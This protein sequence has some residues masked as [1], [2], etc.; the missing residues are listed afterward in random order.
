MNTQ[1]TSHNHLSSSDDARPYIH[2]SKASETFTASAAAVSGMPNATALFKA[3]EDPKPKTADSGN[4]N[5]VTVNTSGKIDARPVT[6]NEMPKPLS[7][8]VATRNQL[9]ALETRA[10]KLKFTPYVPPHL[11]ALQSNKLNGLKEDIPKSSHTQTWSKA[12]ASTAVSKLDGTKK[13]AEPNVHID[14]GNK[15]EPTLPKPDTN[16]H[17]SDTPKPDTCKSD[18]RTYF[19]AKVAPETAAN[20]QSG[21]QSKKSGS[22]AQRDDN[23]RADSRAPKPA[24]DRATQP[25]V[26]PRAVVTFGNIDE[27]KK[28]DD[29]SSK[30]ADDSKR[31]NDFLKNNDSIIEKTDPIIDRAA[32]GQDLDRK[33]TQAPRSKPGHGTSTT[34]IKPEVSKKAAEVQHSEDNGIHTS[35]QKPSYSQAL[36]YNSTD[37]VDAAESSKPVQPTQKDLEETSI[38]SPKPRVTNI[39]KV[40]SIEDQ[41]PAHLRNLPKPILVGPVVKRNAERAV[42]NS[43]IDE[44][45]RLER[46]IKRNEASHK[47]V[48]D[49]EPGTQYALELASNE[50]TRPAFLAEDLSDMDQVEDIAAPSLV[51][52]AE[53]VTQEKAWRY[54]NKLE[55]FDSA[56]PGNSPKEAL[57]HELAGWDG[58]WMTPHVE[59]DLRQQFNH[60]NK[61]QIRYL[62]SWISGRVTE[63]LNAPFKVDTT[64]LDWK[65]GALPASGTQKQYQIYPLD[66][67]M[68]RV[69]LQYGPVDWSLTPTEKPNDPYSHTE[70]RMN[71]S[72]RTSARKFHKE[73]IARLKAREL[74][75]YERRLEIQEFE[76]RKAQSRAEVA[77]KANIYLRPV[78]ASDGA[79]LAQIYNYYVKE[80]VHAPEYED[81]D[82]A[83]WQ[84]RINGARDEKLAFLVAVL[85][86]NKI[87]G[88]G[89]N[90]GRG[91]RGDG[92]RGRGTAFGRRRERA[93]DVFE[94]MVVGFAYGEDHAG[95]HTMYEY[96]A[97]L[98]VFVDPNHTRQGIGRTLMDRMMASLDRSYQSY[99]GTDFIVPIGGQSYDVGGSRDM[100]KLMVTVGFHYGQE[101]EFEWRK[102][103]LEMVW[104]FDHI[105]TYPCFGNKFGKG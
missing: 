89:N 23:V 38:A 1:P 94:E 61:R 58:N 82:M 47:P 15:I 50:S 69:P 87:M 67:I 16:T 68:R 60:N 78:Q 52:A 30:K 25:H 56:Q 41:L 40:P 74:A 17:D 62:D 35:P 44:G 66:C 49:L 65:S 81:T 12:S 3:A 98:Q 33:N 83:N 72:S 5:K 99:Q 84:D 63:A 73:H 80:S 71:Q 70:E 32:D 29:V 19:Q 54:F 43:T 6:T 14:K 36:R 9:I 90:R 75:K 22:Q 37:G 13:K 93:P 31:V 24:V 34:P 51:P 76:R 45:K 7:E 88:R 8:N 95:R 20:S 10:E 55:S 79:Q 100:H 91:S 57:V 96:V 48:I 53:R 11:R 4:T 104:D 97:E 64:D 27:S 59:W 26:E 2:S 46:V 28:E 21:G 85:K 42:M 86:S 102:K 77:P 103:W 101:Q 18:I 92:S 39:P 105:A